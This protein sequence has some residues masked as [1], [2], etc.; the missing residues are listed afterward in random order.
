MLRLTNVSTHDSW[1]DAVL[2][3]FLI[4][5]F[6]IESNTEHSYDNREDLVILD[7]FTQSSELTNFMNGLKQFS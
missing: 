6:H 7:I 3:R 2:V 5:F 1:T 4:I